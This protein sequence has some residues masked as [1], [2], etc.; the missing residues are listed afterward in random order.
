M[1]F[2][3]NRVIYYDL[4]AYGASATSGCRAAVASFI[5]GWTERLHELGYLAGGYGSP[6]TSHIADWASNSPPPDL[7]WIAVW[8]FDAYDPSATVW[9][10][11]YLSNSLWSNHQRIRQYAGGHYETWGGVK[12]D[13]DSNVLDGAVTTIPLAAGAPALVDLQAQEPQAI[14][15]V[16]GMQLLSEATGWVLQGE[17]LLITKDG[18]S[19]WQDITP[20][21]P[22]MGTS[23]RRR[24]S[25]CN[26]AGS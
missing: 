9:T 3:G 11:K 25:I 2:L 16:K 12:L 7:I 21:A 22:V 5:R 18:G 1:G 10:P 19:T 6:A 13:M 4:E 24:C 26:R 23:W 15:T 8:S 20:S 14:P 17:R